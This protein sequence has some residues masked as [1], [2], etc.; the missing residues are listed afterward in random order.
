MN[1]FKSFDSSNGDI[2]AGSTSTSPL[3]NIGAG[4]RGKFLMAQGNDKP[5]WYGDVIDVSHGGSGLSSTT[6]NGIL[7]GGT[8]YEML[9][10]EYGGSS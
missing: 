5:I 3:N 2:C 4:A 8:T 1:V 7:C 10:L 6:A 9:V